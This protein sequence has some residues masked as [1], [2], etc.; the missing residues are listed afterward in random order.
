M[1]KLQPQNAAAW[2][3]RCWTRAVIGRLQE[4]L[5]D[6]NEALKLQ[7]DYINALDSRGFV[8]LRI[9]KYD[10]SIADYDAAL[11]IEPKKVASLYGRG[12]A[13]RRKGDFAAG[14]VDIAAARAIKPN[15]M[16]EFT[17]YGLMPPLIDAPQRGTDQQPEREDAQAKAQQPRARRN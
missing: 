17:R 8:L 13:K 11:Q 16:T 6:C 2:N 4:A 14:N 9:G 15:I 7:P 12:M 10:E 5:G 1:T 3:S